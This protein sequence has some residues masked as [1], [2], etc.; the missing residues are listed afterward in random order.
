MI[1]KVMLTYNISPTEVEEES[2]AQVGA[3]FIKPKWKTE[4]NLIK[5]CSD[6]DVVAL[7][8]GPN[9]PITKRVID[10]IPNLKILSRMGR[11]EK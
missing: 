10:A 8:I 6:T 5:I 4:D 9:A 11:D 7:L 1:Y 2:L 3:K